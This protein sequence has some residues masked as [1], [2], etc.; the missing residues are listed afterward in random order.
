VPV[1]AFHPWSVI[2]CSNLLANTAAAAVAHGPRRR[3]STTITVTFMTSHA[4]PPTT[5]ASAN[6]SVAALIGGM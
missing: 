2:R 3:S 5:P 1:P 6:A 4:T